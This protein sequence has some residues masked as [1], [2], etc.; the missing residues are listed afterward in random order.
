MKALEGERGRESTHNKE[1]KH[2]HED[3]DTGPHDAGHEFGI[4]AHLIEAQICHIDVQGHQTDLIKVTPSAPHRDFSITRERL[5]CRAKKDETSS[6]A[7][8][9]R[10]PSIVSL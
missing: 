6:E 7:Q 1:E 2:V 3:P 10:E 4:G 8:M 5:T 9:A